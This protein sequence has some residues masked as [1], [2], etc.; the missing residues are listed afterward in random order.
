[1]F[2]YNLHLI[3]VYVYVW[4][5][6]LLFWLKVVIYVWVKSSF[7]KG[8]MYVAVAQGN[9]QGKSRFTMAE[10]GMLVSDK[11]SVEG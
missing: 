9:I 3:C 8:Q 11:R 7:W 5:F 6:L 2:I 1:M 4:Q 10:G